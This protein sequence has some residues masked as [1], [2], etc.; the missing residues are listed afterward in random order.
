MHHGQEAV[1]LNY[2]FSRG[3]DVAG[4]DA[5]EATLIQDSKEG[6]WLPSGIT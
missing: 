1:V 2:S 6:P 3:S 4:P 5:N